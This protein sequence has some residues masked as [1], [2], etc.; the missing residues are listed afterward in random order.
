MRSNIGTLNAFIRITIGFT[1]L[2]YTTAKMVR[3]PWKE[4]YVWWIM[5][6]AMK[7]AEGIVRYC[8]IVAL[9]E[10]INKNNDETTINPS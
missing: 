8:P 9:M 10:A 7:V 1:L 2:S 6:A 3:K 5:I 4:N